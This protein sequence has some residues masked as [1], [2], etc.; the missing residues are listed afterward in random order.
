MGVDIAND[1]GLDPQSILQTTDAVLPALA[2]LRDQLLVR[3]IRRRGVAVNGGE[4][5]VDL[6]DVVGDA[7]RFAEQLL[8]SLE[9]T[10]AAP[11]GRNT[12]GSRGC[13]P[14]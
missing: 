1:A 5:L 12:A 7:L 8:R 11:G 10:A 2:G 3:L 13:L 6:L 9:R 14:G 4:R